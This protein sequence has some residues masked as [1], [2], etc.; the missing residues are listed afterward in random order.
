MHL[1]ASSKHDWM[2]VR[3]KDVDRLSH[4]R[5]NPAPP[6]K[7]APSTLIH[8][9]H[10]KSSWLAHKPFYSVIQTLPGLFPYLHTEEVPHSNPNG[11]I[12]LHHFSKTK[13]S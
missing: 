2:V 8:K 4:E 9:S 12:Y 10:P 6:F 7:V 11:C 5:S 3:T 13:D 1:N